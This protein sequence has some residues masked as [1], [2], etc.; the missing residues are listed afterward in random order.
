MDKRAVVSL[1]EVQVRELHRLQDPRRQHLVDLLHG[2]HRVI[3]EGDLA[4]RFRQHSREERAVLQEALVHGN[5]VLLLPQVHSEL[6][7]D[8][9]H[10]GQLRC[11]VCCERERGDPLAQA[12]V[13]PVCN[14]A[15]VQH[16]GEHVAQLLPR[17]AEGRGS[18]RLRLVLFPREERGQVVA[19]VH[20]VLQHKVV[21]EVPRHSG[22]LE[23][24]LRDEVHEEHLLQARIQ[25]CVV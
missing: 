9:V 14:L 6:A 23:Q 17:H 4:A 18:R 7:Q 1:E 3:V 24:L 19:D 13:E 16:V 15:P 20:G 10:V 12:L 25:H 8:L 11:A 22:P 2:L 21:L 5:R